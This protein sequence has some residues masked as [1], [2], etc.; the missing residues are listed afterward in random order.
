MTCSMC[1]SSQAR[2]N[3][4]RITSIDGRR[5]YF[6]AKATRPVHIEFPIEYFDPSDEGKVARLN[7]SLHG[8]RDASPNWAKEYMTFL[9]ECGVRATSSTSA[10]S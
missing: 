8:T 2:K 4:S 10:G 6:Y 3:P 7:L 9:E 1:A 5:A